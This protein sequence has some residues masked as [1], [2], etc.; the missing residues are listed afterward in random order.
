MTSHVL[1]QYKSDPW[2]THFEDLEGRLAFT[3]YVYTLQRVI[4][5]I[6][7]LSVAIFAACG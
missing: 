6:L 7:S 3:V 4:N 5:I 1:L 2:A